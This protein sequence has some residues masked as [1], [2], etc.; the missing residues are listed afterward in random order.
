MPTGLGRRR[1][2]A[3]E[4][5]PAHRAGLQRNLDGVVGGQDRH[6]VAPAP[7]SH[8]IPGFGAPDDPVGGL[9]PATVFKKCL[10]RKTGFRFTFGV[11]RLDAAL[12]TEAIRPFNHG[13]RLSR[14]RDGWTRM[15][16]GRA[17]GSRGDAEARR[18]RG[19]KIRSRP[20]DSV[21]ARIHNVKVDFNYIKVQIA[22]KTRRSWHLN[23]QTGLKI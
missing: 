16:R 7:N 4:N 19:G 9:K 12:G 1:L 15:G 13:S 20:M 5:G 17:A 10:S 3:D 11:R 22:P 21:G 14:G 23:A 6:G 18:G 2:A 8:R